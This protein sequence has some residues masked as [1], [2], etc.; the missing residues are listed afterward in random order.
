M[1]GLEYYRLFIKKMVI[2]LVIFSLVPL[3]LINTVLRH[4]FLSSYSDKVM[5]HMTELIQKHKQNIDNFLQER[6][7]N[8][9]VLASS[10]SMEQLTNEDFL[11]K[12]LDI[13]Q[14]EY[15]NA[16]VDLGIVDINGIQIA[17]AGKYKLVSANYKDSTWFNQALKSKYYISDVF[18][19]LRG[20]PHFI[21][22]VKKQWNNK[23]YIIRAT[24]D[25]NTF[26][27]MVEKIRI[28]ATGFAFIVNKTGQLQTRNMYNLQTINGTSVL[29]FLNKIDLQKEDV[30]A[31]QNLQY[32]GKEFIFFIVSLKEGQWRLIF[33]QEQGDAFSEL[34]KARQMGIIILLC[35][36]IGVIL[37]YYLMSR[38]M[39]R[40]IELSEQ[41]REKM[42][43]QLIESGKLASIGELAA[44]IA[45]EINNPVA[46]MVEEAGWIQD[47]L[48]EE[49][50]KDSENVQ[51][52]SRSL[53]Q[54]KLQGMRCKDITFKLLSFA[55][56][57]DP[58]AVKTQIN[59]LIEE[60]VKLSKQR[61]KYS[62]I[63]IKTEFEQDLPELMASP[64]EL[65]QVFLN[66]FN[67]AI[68]AIGTANDEGMVSIVTKRTGDTVLISFSD[69]GQGIPKSNIA[70][71]FDP[72]FTTKPIGKGTGIGL[73][74]CHGIIKKLGGD[75]TVSSEVG[76]GTTFELTIPLFLEKDTE[77]PLFKEL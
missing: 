52:F 44:G 38:K 60:I 72:F 59:D 8:I 47:L 32:R 54:I 55:R 6:L 62:H 11:K 46:I 5:E 19:G 57:T 58:R 63:E 41:Q 4:Y 13:L 42:N 16:F 30:H 70:R 68:D 3:L 43:E 26:N 39:I 31:V 20:Q 49:D 71:I 37:I 10:N 51:E 48:K 40:F 77:T 12:N 73:S 2:L 56:K 75:I 1:T 76:I 61:A 17:Y 66:L 27:S 34:Y 14:K 24:I 74:I 18:L 9:R 22:A 33:Q 65:Q 35:G 21:V 69:N 50:F 28:G 53:L 25:F 29:D 45:H 36:S 7:N 15:D 23:D 64:S 67:N